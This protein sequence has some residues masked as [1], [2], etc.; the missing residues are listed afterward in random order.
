HVFGAWV[1]QSFTDSKRYVFHLLQ[2]G[3]GMPDRDA[4]LDPSPKMATLREQYRSHIAATLKLAN[5]A[6]AESRAAGV[7]SLEI[8]IAQAHAPD[9]DAADVFKQNNPW[10]R[11]DFHVNA[12]GMDWNAY[13]AAAGLG[14]ES[15][16]VVW[17][18]SA[19]T[20]TSALVANESIE[21]WKDYLK[22]HLI[23]HYA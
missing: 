2:G 13:F 15:E 11:G 20:G 14:G 8:R 6:D 12:P 10:K 18:P 7:L 17:Q 21:A 23:E 16:F 4:Y 19:V 22:F 9:A 3:L 5:I 1:N